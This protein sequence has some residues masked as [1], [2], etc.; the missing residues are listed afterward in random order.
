MWILIRWFHLKP[1]DLDI[2]CLQKKHKTRFS[3][4]WAKWLN[5]SG[6]FNSSQIIKFESNIPF[7]Y[8]VRN[9]SCS[10]GA[11]SSVQPDQTAPL[12]V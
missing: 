8:L 11:A 5:Y 3:M 1:A 4:I 12:A 6:T 10:D 9:E 2:Q 7:P